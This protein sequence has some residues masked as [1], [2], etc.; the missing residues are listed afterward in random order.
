MNTKKIIRYIGKT[1]LDNSHGVEGCFFSDLECPSCKNKGMFFVEVL[2]Q[3][4][5]WVCNNGVLIKRKYT[6]L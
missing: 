4:E 5:C 6:C 3:F 1:D 2:S